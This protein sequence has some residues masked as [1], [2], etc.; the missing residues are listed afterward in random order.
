MSI[1][2]VRVDALSSDLRQ[3]SNQRKAASYSGRDMGRR[4]PMTK[5]QKTILK[6]SNKLHR[7]LTWIG[8]SVLLLFI[9]SAFTHPLM[10][11]T[12]PRPASFYPPQLSIDSSLIAA[13][14]DVLA[15]HRIDDA[16]IIKVVPTQKGPLLQVSSSLTGPKRYFDPK[17][18][19][20]LADFDR[21]QAIWLAR[22]Y[23]GLEG[24]AVRDIT[25]QSEFD[26]HY[27][28]V[29]RLLPVYKISFDTPDNKTLFVHTETGA[30][31]SYTNDWKSTLQSIFQAVHTWSW[32]NDVEVLRVT[33]MVVLLLS[34]IGLVITG[35]SLV[36]LMKRR[37]IPQKGRRFHRY[38]AHV[39][40]L[41]LLALL[42]SGSFHLLYSSYSGDLAEDRLERKLQ[43]STAEF[44]DTADWLKPFEDLTFN[45]MSIVPGP[46]NTLFFRLS[47]PPARTSELVTRRQSFDGLPSEKASLY[48]AVGDKNETAIDDK[49]MVVHYARELLNKREDIPAS[50]ELITRFGPEYDFRNKR[51]PVWKVSFDDAPSDILYMD[52]VSGILVDR[53]SST[54]LFERYIFS[55]MHKWDFLVPLTGRMGRDAVVTLFLFSIA[56]LGG[57]GIYMRIR[58]SK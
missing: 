33:V 28:W 2:R 35:T 42:L 51:L 1:T 5:L 15:R 8:A 31:G 6:Q 26:T 48:F 36:Y 11:W 32:L 39:V 40:W 37:K 49:T 21:Q 45:A 14:P 54:T 7:Y 55:W 44:S 20:E 47:I 29:N 25:L 18:K 34:V 38:M 9:V 23:S 53:M 13:I 3:N 52:A 56:V 58:S 17:T 4:Y 10:I 43:I 57:I 16:A 46:D 22:Y 24:T 41:P 50:A 19:S 12:G 30:M 27:P